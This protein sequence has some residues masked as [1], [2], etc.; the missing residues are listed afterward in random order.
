[1]PRRIKSTMIALCSAA[2]TMLISYHDLQYHTSYSTANMNTTTTTIVGNNNS[3][4]NAYAFLMAGCNPSQPGAYIGYLYNILAASYMLTNSKYDI[5]V[6]IRMS[7]KTNDE[8]LPPQ[9]ERWLQSAGVRM[10]YLYPRMAMK[11]QTPSS[12]PSWINFKFLTWLSMMP[13][14]SSIR[15][16]CHCVI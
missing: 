3:S 6:M 10:K 8:R 1:M 2:L 16:F 11:R 5:V 13:C 12:L 14:Y 7:V 4:K 9:H 15:M